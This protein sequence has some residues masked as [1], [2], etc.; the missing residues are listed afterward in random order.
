MIEQT[1]E[2]VLEQYQK[3][4]HKFKKEVDLL[5]SR[6]RRSSL[7][8]LSIF[9][10]T[11]GIAYFFFPIIEIYVP[12]LIVGFVVFIFLVLR[13]ENLK[14]QRDLKKEILLLNQIEIAEQSV[15]NSQ[16]TYDINFERYKNGDLTG[17]D[18]NLYQNQLSSAKM[19]I[20]NAQI[21]YKLEV[22][23]MK[24]QT[25]YDW[26]TRNSIVPDEYKK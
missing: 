4:E 18:L 17:M 16:M 12:S 24:I 13:H 10:A 11:V 6:I 14:R 9:A 25:L 23:N 1:A 8:R 20:S 26:E 19:E 3:R 2:N 21:S 5:N 15:R 7:L 22:L